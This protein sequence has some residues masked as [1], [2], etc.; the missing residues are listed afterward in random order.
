MSG[1]GT[2]VVGGAS[3][4]PV[5]NNIPLTDTVSL[6]DLIS[7]AN[8]TQVQDNLQKDETPTT[9]TGTPTTT[10]TPVPITFRVLGTPGVYTAFPGTSNK[11]TTDSG[12]GVLGGGDYDGKSGPFTD[13]FTWTFGIVNGRFTGTVSGLL[14][15]NCTNSDCTT[16]ETH[17]ITPAKVDFP[18]SFPAATC[19]MGSAR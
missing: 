18:A 5:N 10:P 12:A 8:Q 13:D 11:Y 3:N 15:A 17:T 1:P 6:Q 7:D 14:D 9:P 4:P 16:I 19:L 2:T